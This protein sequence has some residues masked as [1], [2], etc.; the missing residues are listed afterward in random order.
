MS[1][2]IA[3]PGRPGRF[4]RRLVALLREAVAVLH[5]LPEAYR[6]ADLIDR[7]RTAIARA[8]AHTATTPQD[9]SR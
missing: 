3:R 1:Q 5:S 9:R 4:H 6:P 2:P 8:D 7:M